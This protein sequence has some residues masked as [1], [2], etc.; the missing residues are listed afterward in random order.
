MPAPTD[1]TPRRKR[2]PPPPGNPSRR[3]R[4]KTGKASVRRHPA[5]RRLWPIAVIAAGVFLAAYI[6]DLGAV[7]RLMWAGLS[8]QLGQRAC[9]ASAAVMVLLGAALAWASYRPAPRPVRKAAAKPRRRP[10]TNREK[11][12]RTEPEEA[13]PSD[14]QNPAEPG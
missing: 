1:A 11:R 8:G 3:P 2:T 6:L 10:P 14:G 12:V 4:T 9:I 7:A 13:V 5:T